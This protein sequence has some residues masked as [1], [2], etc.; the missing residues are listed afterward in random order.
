MRLFRCCLEDVDL[1]A[2]ICSLT[3]PHLHPS[4]PCSLPYFI[5]CILAELADCSLYHP[6]PSLSSAVAIMKSIYGLALAVA[7]SASPVLLESSSK[8]AAP[9]LSATERKRDSKQLHGDV[10]GPCHSDSR[11]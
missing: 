3:R 6:F 4:S 1:I 7:A 5:N 11:R 10:Q 9:I 8:N 2:G